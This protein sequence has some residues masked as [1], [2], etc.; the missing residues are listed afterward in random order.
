[1]PENEGTAVRAFVKLGSRRNLIGR[2]LERS[3]EA[4]FA[5]I[6]VNDLIFSSG[7]EQ[8]STGTM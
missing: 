1:M 8:E 4:F 7:N 5:H 2:V 3:T 6:H